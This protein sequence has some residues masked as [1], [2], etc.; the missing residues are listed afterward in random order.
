M[1]N[2]ATREFIRKHAEDDV[3][4]L[5]LRGSKDPEVDL[6]LALSQIGG[7]QKAR[8]KL[9]SWAATDGIVYPP[10]LS[11]EQCSSEQTARYKAGIA[12]KG[13]LMAD[14]TGGFGVDFALMAPAFERAV[15][16]ERNSQLCAISSE[17]FVT[18]GLSNVEVVC[19]DGTEYLHSISR[20][21]LIFIDPARR[22]DH[23]ARTYGIADC[24]P[25]VLELMDELTQKA[26]RLLIKL[27]P[28]LDW[29]KAMA[30]VGHV[31]EVH[32]VSVDNECKELLVLVEGGK[33][34]EEGGMRKEEGGM[35]RVFCVNLLSDGSAQ[36]FEFDA[37]AHLPSNHSSFL[38]PRSSFLVTPSSFLFAPNASV[39]K[40]GCFGLLEQRF[41]A[42]QLEANSHLF[43]SDRDVP[44][45]PGRRFIIEHTTSLNKRQLKAALGGID[46]ANIAVRNFPLTAEQL[47]RKLKL[48]DGGDTYIF[49]TT[50]RGDAHQLFICRK[51]G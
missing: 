12:G 15:Y 29:R 49:A 23:G 31:A 9:P 26:D 50:V 4:Q 10:H 44:D 42:S 33:G 46:R 13:R 30:D 3:R 5:A 22:D 27:S 18:L 24:T 47:R 48:N 11:M 1:V 14:L 21:D 16:V 32:I 41:G 51:I 37:S 34:N 8:E 28:M 6:P 45:F 7:R 40:A 19:G 39:M 35:T 20:A 43:V 17:N 2:Q 38:V 36:R 25:N